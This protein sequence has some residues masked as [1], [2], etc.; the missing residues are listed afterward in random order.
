MSTTQQPATRRTQQRD[1][2]LKAFV[3]ASRPL[4]PQE[5]LE[6][7]VETVPSLGIATVYRTLKKF[8]SEDVIQV[9][10]LPGATNRYELAGL[11]HHHHFCCRACD[12]VF[13]IEGCPNQIADLAPKGF[14]LEA[15]ELV[16]Y[17]VCSSCTTADA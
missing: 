12:R 16:L 6:L 15:H 10:E 11:G 5:V 9:V 2:I 8:L 4:G 3:D 7:A 17:G 1:A 14:Q 13:D